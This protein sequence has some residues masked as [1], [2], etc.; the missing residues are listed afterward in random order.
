MNYVFIVVD[1]SSSINQGGN[2]TIGKLNDLLQ[3]M[4]VEISRFDSVMTSVVT[5]ADTAHFYHPL[6]NK[7]RFNEF[8]S[9]QFMGRSNL[10][11]A[12]DLIYK[13]I[14]TKNLPIESTM[15]ILISDGQSTDNYKSS[16]IK[17]DELGDSIRFSYPVGSDDETLQNHVGNNAN[18]YI[19]KKEDLIESVISVIRGKE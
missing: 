3:D 4:S 2:Q 5:Y 9:S 18:H 13:E 14:N 12:Y 10:G 11:K 8:P 19:L 7:M 17:L 6:T 16:L 15:I 1:S